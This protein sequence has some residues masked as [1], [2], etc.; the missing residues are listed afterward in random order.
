MSGVVDNSGGH[1]AAIAFSE[2]SQAALLT[3]ELI[4][5]RLASARRKGAI[6]NLNA[7]PDKGRR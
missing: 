1:S 7:Y 5:P 2:A 4:S 6:V 3:W